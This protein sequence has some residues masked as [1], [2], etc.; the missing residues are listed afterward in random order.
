[1]SEQDNEQV[2]ETTTSTDETVVEDTQ[3]VDDSEEVTAQEEKTYTAEQFKQVLARAKKAEAEA[4]SLKGTKETK[5]AQATQN[6]NSSSLTEEV[7]ERKILKSQGMSDALIEELSAIAKVRGKGLIET[8][9]DPLFE[10]VKGIEADKLAKAKAK[11]GASKGAGSVKKEKSFNSVGLTKEEHKE[12]WLK[13][14][15]R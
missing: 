12:L 11:L 9:S 1:M 14:Q 8:Q 10:A 3:T 6:I 7:V 5:P 15:G 13:S 2:V 4:K